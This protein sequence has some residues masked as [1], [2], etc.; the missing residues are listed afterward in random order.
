MHINLD[1]I[2]NKGKY[3]QRIYNKEMYLE[4]RRFD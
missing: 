3:N 1:E 2:E 4:D